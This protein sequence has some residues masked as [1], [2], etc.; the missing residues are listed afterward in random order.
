MAAAVA[1]AADDD[2]ACVH[3]AARRWSGRAHTPASERAR[4]LKGMMIQRRLANGAHAPEETSTPATST[5]SRSGPPI[6]RRGDP[7]PPPS[8]GI[9]GDRGRSM[10]AAAATAAEVKKTAWKSS[11]LMKVGTSELLNHSNAL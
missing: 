3:T 9:L 7:A 2:I 4:A 6:R 5:R 1:V 8:S 11:I 10:G